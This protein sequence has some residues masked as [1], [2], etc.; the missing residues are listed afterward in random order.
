M[1]EQTIP[2]KYRKKKVSIDNQWKEVNDFGRSG[3][4]TWRYQDENKKQG[5][6]ASPFQLR[7][8]AATGQDERNRP[9]Q[10]N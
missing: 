5:H 7:R 2:N 3:L 9:C 4:S 1:E 8:T 10:H 6:I